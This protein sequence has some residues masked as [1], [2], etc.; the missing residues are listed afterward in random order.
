MNSDLS[1]IIKWIRLPLAIL[2][3]FVHCSPTIYDEYNVTASVLSSQGVFV[4]VTD[5]IAIVANCA[6]PTF[7]V[8]SGYLF[9]C[10]I[11]TL[12]WKVY[13]KK[14]KSRCQSLLY[15]FLFWNLLVFFWG[16]FICAVV[17]YRDGLSIVDA[18]YGEISSI[19]ISD[20]FI[21]YKNTGVPCYMILWY[22]R[23]LIFLSIIS[24]LFYV[25]AKYAKY[26][27]PIIAVA[28]YLFTDY[29]WHWLQGRAIFFFGIGCW[30]GVNKAN[31]LKYIT[32]KWARVFALATIIV[33][34]TYTLSSYHVGSIDR[35]VSIGVVFSFFVVAS[36]LVKRNVLTTFTS[37]SSS[38]MFVYCTHILQPANKCTIAAGVTFI[39]Q[40]SIGSV[41][42]IGPFVSYICTP[43]VV[44]FICIAMY[45]CLI[46]IHPKFTHLIC[47]I[48][49][50]SITIS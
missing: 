32:S 9:F 7:F 45:R 28:I 33:C 49:D 40:K 50:N 3:I 36:I 14:L 10:N 47:G 37:Y 20:I 16:L 5:F 39:L 19:N 12:N 2:V 25:M 29:H 22:V 23:D 15:P 44:A 6:V 18:L 13:C 8:L 34:M 4:K 30:L 46:Y 48:R 41:P 43:I 42:V 1:N 38:A 21:S 26:V 31:V 17:A 27:Y 35:I 11:E 24:P